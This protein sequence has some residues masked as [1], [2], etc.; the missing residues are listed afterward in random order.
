MFTLVVGV[1]GAFACLR[2][3]KF[4][5]A[6]MILFEMDGRVRIRTGIELRVAFIRTGSLFL[7]V[8]GGTVV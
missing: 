7:L 2:G 5:M 1:S 8:K 6:V 3:L 4:K